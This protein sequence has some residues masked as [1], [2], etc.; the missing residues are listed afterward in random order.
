MEKLKTQSEVTKIVHAV[1]G[2]AHGRAKSKY[3]ESALSGRLSNSSKLWSDVLQF[4]P[5]PNLVLPPKLA[6][7]FFQQTDSL[8]CW[9]AHEYDK[10]REYFLP[11][12]NLATAALLA[13]NIISSIKR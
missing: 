1:F 2:L 3:S 6:R 11:E 9:V 7:Y 12:R 8:F 5:W 10:E 4:F 13:A